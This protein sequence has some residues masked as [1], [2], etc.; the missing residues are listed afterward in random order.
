MLNPGLAA[1]FGHSQRSFGRHAKNRNV[2]GFSYCRDRRI[3]FVAYNLVFFGVN[4]IHF[5]FITAG[6]D[7]LDDRIPDFAG[8]V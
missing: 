3:S 5:A 4:R 8:C 1:F 2:Y 7:V 6:F